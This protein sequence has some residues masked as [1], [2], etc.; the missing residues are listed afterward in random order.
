MT[1]QY[2]VGEFSELISLLEPVPGEWL[3]G[4]V[5]GLRRRVECSPVAALVPLAAEATTIADMVCWAALDDGDTAGFA[6]RSAAAAALH[7]FVVSANLVA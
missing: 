1:Q 7:E 6:R 3:A 2:I 5:R 4:A